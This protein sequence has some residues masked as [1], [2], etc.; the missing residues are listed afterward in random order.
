MLLR[1]HSLWM[2]IFWIAFSLLWV[3][4]PQPALA[5]ST[6]EPTV[7]SGFYLVTS[8][9][10]VQLYRKNY[11]KGNPD[12]IQVADLSQGAAIRLIFRSVAEPRT[13]KGMFGGNDS[14]FR[15]QSLK[16]FWYELSTTDKNAFC[17]NNGQFFNMKEDP[18]RLV[19][20]LKEDGTVI[21]DGYGVDDHPGQQLM[22]EIWPDAVDISNLT[23]ESLYTSTAPDILGGLTEDANKSAKKFVGRTFVGVKN[24]NPDGKYTTFL[25]FSTL[26]SFQSDAAKILKSFGAQKVMMLDGG[27]S[28]QLIC[29]GKPY[30]PSDRLIPQALAILSASD[31]P[32]SLPSSVPPPQ[33]TLY[34]T[35]FPK[36]DPRLPSRYASAALS[37]FAPPQT[38]IN[39]SVE[40][41]KTLDL[42]GNDILWIPVLIIPLAGILMLVISRIRR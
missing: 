36:D 27:G 24:L 34:T 11:P 28:T 25:V 17:I 33:N 6:P 41:D 37:G 38:A 20:P 4:I 22:L 23:K 8:A 26:T 9:K 15:Y 42:L 32:T 13:G 35:P 31:Q 39:D 18:T 30:V 10:G 40:V 21:T 19:F 29:Q 12:F 1:V 16:Q 5:A 2:R 7:P 14:S 3:A